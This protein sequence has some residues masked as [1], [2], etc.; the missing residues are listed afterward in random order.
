MTARHSTTMTV[1]TAIPTSIVQLQETIAVSKSAST[2]M[3]AVQ[4]FALKLISQQ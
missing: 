3:E 1:P 2:L 4:K